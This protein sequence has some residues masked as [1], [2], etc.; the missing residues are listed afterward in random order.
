MTI[1]MIDKYY[2]IRGG[3]ERY[4]FELTTTL[5]KMGHRVV[6]FAMKHPDNFPSPWEPYFVNH[7]DYD[8]LSGAAKAIKGPAITG[9]MIYSLHAQRRLERLIREVKPDVAHVHMIDH[10]LSPSI[11]HI[12]KRHEVPVVY[13]AHQYKLVCPNYRLY[14]MRTQ[15]VCQKCLGSHPFHPIVERCQK[16]SILAGTMLSAETV[17][18]KGMRIYHRNVDL[19]HSPSR[20]MEK[21][22]RDGGLPGRKLQHRLYMLN[23]DAYRPSTRSS[24]YGLYYGRLAKEKGIGTLL[25]AW[26]RIRS[27]TAELWL[28]GVGPERPALER[29]AVEKGLRVRFLGYQSGDKLKDL[30][31]NALFVSVPSE[32]HDNSPLVIYESFAWGK[33]VIGSEMGGIPELIDHGINGFLHPSGDSEALAAHMEK[34]I[35]RP[36]LALEMGRNGRAK[37]DAEFDATHHTQWMLGWYRRLREAA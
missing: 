10:Q 29:Q 22:L 12:L 7:V 4:L 31:T 2:H 1:L 13:T 33:P 9:R 25:T 28:A 11:L 36:S 19:F 24:N 17:V 23:L 35:S 14:N 8:T 16:D 32:W 30:V 3:A 21:Q 5:I 26:A 27:R 6:P 20:F 15:A 37:A 18:H 34:L